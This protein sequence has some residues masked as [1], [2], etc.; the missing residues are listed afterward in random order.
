[1]TDSRPVVEHRRNRRERTLEGHRLFCVCG[2]STQ[3]RRDYDDALQEFRAHAPMITSGVV[4]G[5]RVETLTEIDED[6]ATVTKEELG[7][8]ALIQNDGDH[9]YVRID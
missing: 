4:I 1:M 3:E 2:F 5:Q 6:G 8:Y 7:T 9:T